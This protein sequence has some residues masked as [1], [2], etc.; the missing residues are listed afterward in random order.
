MLVEDGGSPAKATLVDEFE[1]S[2]INSNLARKKH[3]NLSLS[4][5][6]KWRNS[7]IVK[8]KLELTLTF[9]MA[10][11]GFHRSRWGADAIVIRRGDVERVHDYCRV[12]MEYE[13]NPKKKHEFLRDYL[14]VRVIIK[15]GLRTGEV[16][17]LE[18]EN[19]NFS[20]RS[21]YVLD[22]KQKQLYPLPLDVLTLQLIQDLIG[23]RLEGYVF[24]R[25]TSWRKVKK[26]LPLSVQ[27]VWHVVHELGGAVGVGG[28]K[29]RTLR[30]YFAAKWVEE[31]RRPGSKRTLVG[32]QR[33]LRHKDLA[34]TAIYISKLV[35]FEDL[36]A[37]YEGVQNEPFV[38][39]VARVSP[40]CICR[41]CGNLPFCKFAP[42]PSCVES[43]RYKTKTLEKEEMERNRI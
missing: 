40:E 1:V 25:L 32:L 16:C 9:A 26:D 15:I 23:D 41:N 18:I 7:K 17:S 35:F 20:D 21:F 29:P 3:F 4:A 27:E 6:R 2:H 38:E 37:E 11:R 24:Q 22:S 8:A 13:V 34:T 39:G 31:M 19:I 36:Q 10:N 33:I 42:L 43:C 30:E 12:R 5:V 28:L 14:I